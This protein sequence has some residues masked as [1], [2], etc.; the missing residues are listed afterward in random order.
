[1][2]LPGSALCTSKTQTQTSRWQPKESATTSTCSICI[3]CLLIHAEHK[4]PITHQLLIESCLCSLLMQPNRARCQ[5]V[6]LA[7]WNISSACQVQQQSPAA[8]VTTLMQCPAAAQACNVQCTAAL[9]TLYC[10]LVKCARR[11][12]SNR[13]LRAATQRLS[14]VSSH[15]VSA[16]TL[17][18]HLA[19]W[20]MCIGTVLICGHTFHFSLQTTNTP[21][22]IVCR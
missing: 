18:M 7:R 1:M 8:R 2:P 21:T 12:A 11:L 16:K 5:P 17:S 15:A 20:C 6:V 19:Q 3:I 13:G 10:N 22:S 4:A 14:F 9:C